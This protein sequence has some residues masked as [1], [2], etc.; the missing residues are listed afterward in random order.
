MPPYILTP[1]LT[2]RYID[3][4]CA[5]AHG[6]WL[7]VVLVAAELVGAVLH[8]AVGRVLQ[9]QSIFRTHQRHG[10][11]VHVHGDSHPRLSVRARLLFDAIH[12]LRLHAAVQSSRA[13]CHRVDRCHDHVAQVRTFDTCQSVLTTR[14]IVSVAKMIAQGQ[15]TVYS[16]VRNAVP[17]IS[18]IT[19]AVVWP[20]YSPLNLPQQHPQLLF[21]TV[22]SLLANLVG[23]IVVARVCQLNVDVF[24][25]IMVPFTVV[26]I[27]SVFF[28]GCV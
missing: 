16:A 18:L 19:L 15:A 8:G 3:C 5:A 2:A 4:R 28:H 25:Y 23:R 9:R 13:R 12:T 10:G 11:S 22:G 17:L 27:N 20:L 21:L 7:A 14:S 1:I 24:Y 26:T 6:P